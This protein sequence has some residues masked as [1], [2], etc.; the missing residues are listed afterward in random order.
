MDLNHTEHMRLDRL[1][2][3]VQCVPVAKSGLVH[4]FE[5]AVNLLRDKA[6]VVHH[7]STLLGKVN[8]TAQSETLGDGRRKR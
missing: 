6:V 1:D 5:E 2:S 3:Y 7:L 4:E 8:V